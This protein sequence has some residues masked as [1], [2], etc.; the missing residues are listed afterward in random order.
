MFADGLLAN[1]K[2]LVT[3]GGTGLGRSI[4]ERYLQLGAE[5]VI[6]GRRQEVLDQT[7][8]ALRASISGAQVSGLT[9]NVRDAAAVASMME[10]I[11]RERPIDVLVN[12]AAGNFVAPTHRLSA[13][14]VDV[15]LETVLHGAAY[16]T[17]EAGRRWIDA[18]RPGV[19]LSILSISSMMGSAFTVPS[20]MAKAGVLSM[21]RSL[22]VEWGRKQIRLVAVAPGPF[23]TE[24]AWSR[25][26][27]DESAIEPIEKVVPLGRLGSH[28]ELANL[29]AYLVSDGAG[30]V[31]GECITIDGG[32]RW[33]G[34]GTPS[35]QMLEWSEEKWRVLRGASANDASPR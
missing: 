25:L 11:W 30:Y 28:E 3:G 34:G 20:A 17:I 16:C 14:A 12:N 23:K 8:S 29:C 15:V 4:T 26:F 13:H 24:G 10:Q 21:T 2:I 27:P 22:A 1:K 7:V 32:K 5:V 9:C 33:L 19:V 31:T 35:R 18:G 6:C